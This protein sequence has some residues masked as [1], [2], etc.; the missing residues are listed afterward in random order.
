MPE[1]KYAKRRIPGSLQFIA[2]ELKDFEQDYSFKTWQK[3]Q[4]DKKLQKIYFFV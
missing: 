1:F 2:N 4:E 3:Y